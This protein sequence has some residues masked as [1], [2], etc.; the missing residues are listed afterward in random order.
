MK[1]KIISSGLLL[2]TV[3]LFIGINCKK[4]PDK[5]KKQLI[6]VEVVPLDFAQKVA[7]NFH[8]SNFMS[9]K[10]KK[11]MNNSAGAPKAKTLK[12]RLTVK[13][14]E[15]NP[16]FYIF[17]YANNEGFVMVSAEY[18]HEPILAY[19]DHG[20]VKQ[21]TVPAGLMMWIEK[22]IDNITLLRKGLHDNSKRASEAWA[23]YIKS[24]HI[25]VPETV[26]K[27]LAKLRE[28]GAINS[29]NKAPTTQT[30]PD[31]WDPGDPDN[32]NCTPVANVTIGPLLSDNVRWGQWCTYNELLNSMNCSGCGNSRPPTGCVPTA[33][34][35]IIRYWQYPAGYNYSSMP[36]DYG[37]YEVQRLMRDAGQ[38]L[39]MQY[40]RDY[41]CGS[42]SADDSDVPAALKSNTFRYSSATYKN[43]DVGSY[44][45]VQQNLNVGRPVMLGGYSST[46][47]SIWPFYYIGSTGHEW[48]CDG[49]KQIN[50]C[51]ASFL[52]FN[53]NWG[54]HE[55][56]NTDETDFVGWYSFNNW[57][58]NGYNFQYARTMIVNIHP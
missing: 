27:S 11:L 20:E 54:W 47:S 25:P 6:N 33:M 29:F 10:D 2:F 17:N 15:G 1:K 12:N 4:E 37:N 35:Q 41:K 48:I 24:A 30:E 8:A 31:P 34:A 19:V 26:K 56:F 45:E 18:K 51:T 22:T 50:T 16:A 46:F 7:G 3:A 52:Y 58:V 28:T 23:A 42:S 13:D 14:S 55:I 36:R 21:D 9:F 49:Y 57:A 39:N 38:A 5:A 40:S 53:M 32:P 43:Y 44:L